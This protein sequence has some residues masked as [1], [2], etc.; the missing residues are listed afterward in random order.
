M[1]RFWKEPLDP[2]KHKDLMAFGSG[3]KSRIDWRRQMKSKPRRTRGRPSSLLVQKWVYFVQVCSFT[4]Q[5]HGLDSIENMLIVFDQKPAPTSHRTW[6]DGK[7]V[8]GENE[9]Y[10]WPVERLPLYLF[11]EPKRQKVVKALKRALEVFQE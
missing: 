7:G 5:F 6:D 11:E 3:F 8:D 10:F 4:F 1:A 9:R 2:N